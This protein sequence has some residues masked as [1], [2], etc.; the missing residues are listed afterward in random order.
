MYSELGLQEQSYR[1]FALYPDLDVACKNAIQFV[2]TKFPGQSQPLINEMILE[3]FSMYKKAESAFENPRHMFV[4]GLCAK[5]SFLYRVRYCTEGVEKRK[6]WIPMRQAIT[7]FE[8][9]NSSVSFYSDPDPQIVSEESA[10][11][12]FAARVLQGHLFGEVFGKAC[13]VAA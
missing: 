9:E 4:R 5:A 1:I 6:C 10:I 11:V 2:G 3:A 12:L 13:N 8:N 7:E